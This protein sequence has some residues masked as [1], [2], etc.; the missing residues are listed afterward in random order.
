MTRFKLPKRH[1]PALHNIRAS[2]II[3]T[4]Q[5]SRFLPAL[6]AY[7]AEHGSSVTPYHFDGFNL[8]KRLTVLL[9]AIPEVSNKLEKRKNII[10]ATP[11][12]VANGR[13]AAEPPFLDFALV[14]TGEKNTV[15][16]GTSL[17]GKPVF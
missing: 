5:A 8:F 10:R 14:R 11:P 9:P 7:L 17:E 12:I 16:D 15:T 3:D 6:H 2:V 4:H 13:R 1:P